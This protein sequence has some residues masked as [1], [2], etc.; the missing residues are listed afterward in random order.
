MIR[1]T[2]LRLIQEEG[3]DTFK[4][5]I[6]EVIEDTRRA[7]V[8]RVMEMMIPGVYRSPSF[9]DIPHAG[10]KGVMPD[11]AAVDSLMNCPLKLTIDEKGS[12]DIDLDGANKWGYHSFNCT[13]SG[14]QGGLWVTLCQ[15]LIPNDKVNDGA[16]LAT[17]FN[18]PYGTWS[19]PDNLSVSNTLSWMFLI[20]CFT[21]LVHSLN[22]GFCGRGYLE[23]I[24]AA[25]PFT[26]NITQ[27][28]GVNHHGHDGSWSNFEHSCSG[29]SAR[30]AW[31]GETSCAAVW[32]PE[33]DMGDVEAWEIIEPALYLGRNIRPNSGG[34]GKFRGGSGF[35]SVRMVSGTDR[36]VLYHA[37]DGHVHQ[38][39]GIFG[40]Y[41]GSSGYRHTIKNTDMKERIE[42]RLPYP[43]QDVDS[44]RRLYHYPDPHGE[45]DVYLSQICGGHGLG[46]ALERHSELVAEDINSGHLLERYAAAH[47]VVGKRDG[48][49]QWVVDEQATKALR[50]EKRQQRLD[51]SQSVEEWMNSQRDRVAAL[52]FIE[53]VQKMHRESCELSENWLI[54]FKA[55]WDLGDDWQPPAK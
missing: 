48:S 6:R 54:D 4:N 26:G 9:M 41:P 53:P 29:V 22:R 10:D 38:C 3:V 47:G 2:V 7:F 37:R 50:D 32:N 40:G 8:T 44:D 15:T 49:D 25:Y 34:L 46:D 5:F 28:G 16:Y 1:N 27:G 11:F 18:T 45:Y 13:P 24:I 14:I 39:S 17:T 31:D 52:D 36:Q 20:P 43:V 55:F 33:G 12:F 19:N 51:Q 23:E 35:E 42:K 21:G 30:W